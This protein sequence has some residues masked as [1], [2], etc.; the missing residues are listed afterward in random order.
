MNVAKM[1]CQQTFTSIFQNPTT[2]SDFFL[3]KMQ[4]FP[5]KNIV[6]MNGII[7]WVA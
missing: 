6:K 3:P 5:M 4:I 7:Y 1:S 2:S